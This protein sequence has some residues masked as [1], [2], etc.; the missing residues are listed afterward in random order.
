MPLN[1]D[2]HRGKPRNNRAKQCCIATL[3]SKTN[4]EEGKYY[5]VVLSPCKG[6]RKLF[7]RARSSS[8]LKEKNQKNKKVRDLAAGTLLTKRLS[9]FEQPLPTLITFQFIY[10]FIF[11]LF[12]L[13]FLLLCFF[14]CMY[15]IF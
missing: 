5:T 9:P 4:Q 3:Q 14:I 12:S 7:R 10:L 1:K 11:L 6:N 2:T 13:F 8:R 15:I